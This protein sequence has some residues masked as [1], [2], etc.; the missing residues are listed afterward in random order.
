MPFLLHGIYKEDLPVHVGRN[1]TKSLFFI[2]TSQKRYIKVSLPWQD[3][4]SELT[5]SIKIKHYKKET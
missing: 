3:M 5:L 4:T 1:G 2:K